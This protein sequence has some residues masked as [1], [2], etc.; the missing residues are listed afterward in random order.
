[1]ELEPELEQ[2]PEQDPESNAELEPI[3]EVEP[4]LIPES[5]GMLELIPDPGPEPEP[6]LQTVEISGV[7]SDHLRLLC[8]EGVVRD[9][10]GTVVWG[11][12]AKVPVVIE[13]ATGMRR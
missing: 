5:E 13:K 7:R 9:A 6:E 8:E 1:M 2:I 12:E 4:E 11:E 3:L 10:Y